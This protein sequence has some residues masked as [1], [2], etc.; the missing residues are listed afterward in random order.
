MTFHDGTMQRIEGVPPPQAF[1]LVNWDSSGEV[2]LMDAA[3][4]KEENRC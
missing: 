2:G 1:F 3:I 4:L